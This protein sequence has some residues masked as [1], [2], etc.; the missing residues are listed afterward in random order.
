MRLSDTI[1]G[2][3]PNTCGERSWAAMTRSITRGL[4][5]L[6]IAGIVVSASMGRAVAQQSPFYWLVVTLKIGLVEGRHMMQVMGPFPN[7]DVCELTL[8]ITLDG[9]KRQG[10]EPESSACRNDVTVTIPEGG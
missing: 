2:L 10:V 8:K 4:L 1:S 5:V 7:S 3:T 6:A 9:L